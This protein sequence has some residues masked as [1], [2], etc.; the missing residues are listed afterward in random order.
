MLR[1]CERE[2]NDLFKTLPSVCIPA[3][4]SVSAEGTRRVIADL[5]GTETL[6]TLAAISSSIWETLM[7]GLVVF[8][9][10]EHR[11]AGLMTAIK[12]NANP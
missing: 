4:L 10:C 3:R 9:G 1:C 6:S 5:I 12:R 7:F 2:N 8:K 11:H